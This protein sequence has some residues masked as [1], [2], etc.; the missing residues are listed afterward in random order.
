M[1]TFRNFTKEIVS[2]LRF[3]KTRGQYVPKTDTSFNAWGQADFYK[4][5]LSLP[6]HMDQLEDLHKLG[7]LPYGMAQQAVDLTGAFKSR[8]TADQTRYGPTGAT[9]TDLDQR[10]AID[11]S[12]ARL[13]TRDARGG[14]P[15][16]TL[17]LPDEIKRKT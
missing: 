2:K 12:Y 3:S 16:R 10:L 1:T 15:A 8:F 13:T 7:L 14:L 4:E 17:S 9:Q 6:S 11:Q 5:A